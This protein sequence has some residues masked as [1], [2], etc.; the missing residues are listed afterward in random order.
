MVAD[1]INRI[2]RRGPVRI[3]PYRAFGGPGIIRFAG[4]VL[5]NPEITQAEPGERSARAVLRMAER[6]A[7]REIEGE[8]VEIEF[9]DQTTEAISDSE[10]YFEATLEF[11]SSPSDSGAW[12]EAQ[13]SLPDHDDGVPWVLPSL[14]LDDTTR[15]IVI[16]DVDDTLLS[17]GAG[18][19]ART[20][21]ATITGSHLTRLP[22]TGAPQVYRRIAE[23]G[24]DSHGPSPVFYV[25]SSPWNLFDF[26]TAFMDH[27]DFPVGPLMLRDI[28]LN[29]STFGSSH[30]AHKVRGISTILESA[31]NAAVV[32][33]GDTSQQD[34]TAF[35][36]VI[37]EHPERS[38]AAYLRDVGVPEKA[39]LVREMLDG[40]PFEQPITIVE[41]LLEIVE[42]L[43]SGPWNETPTAPPR[44]Q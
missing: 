3:D 14:V 26:L 9:A 1:V 18:N 43:E 19:V 39:D 44:D 11:D 36:T 5:A 22:I 10:G 16:S 13:A 15:K 34:A 12:V 24:A 25:S 21:L 42:D 7:T 20:V 33:I 30:G 4:R 29:R 17:N 27:H 40:T 37:G 23:L 8:R 41:E 6:F 35:S 31:P 38:I 2:R 32:L 28:G